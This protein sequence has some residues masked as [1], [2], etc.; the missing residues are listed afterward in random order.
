MP[1]TVL[2][3]DNDWMA[4][5]DVPAT[6]SGVSKGLGLV[7]VPDAGHHLYLDNPAVFHQTLNDGLAIA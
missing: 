3:G 6:L 2:F 7:Q 4:H 5:P 1:V